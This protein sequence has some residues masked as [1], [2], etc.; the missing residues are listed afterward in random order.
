MKDYLIRFLDNESGATAID[1]AL[2]ASIISIGVISS[3][4]IIASN[5]KNVFNKVGG[6]MT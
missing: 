2:I 5:L 4:T 1:Y 6:N 3:S